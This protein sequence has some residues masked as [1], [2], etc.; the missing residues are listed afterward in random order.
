MKEP[1]GHGRL[2]HKSTLEKAKNRPARR[3]DQEE[4]PVFGLYEPALQVLQLT[5]CGEAAEEPWAQGELRTQ[6]QDQD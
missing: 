4:A 5:D 6:Q 3:T 1:V 2:N